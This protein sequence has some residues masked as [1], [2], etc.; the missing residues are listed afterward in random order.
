[1]PLNASDRIARRK[2][3]L[4]SDEINA[5]II[6]RKQQK[7]LLYAVGRNF[8]EAG[9]LDLKRTAFMEALETIGIDG[10]SAEKE[11]KKKITA[12]FSAYI[13]GLSLE[14]AATD[15]RTIVRLIKL[16][17]KKLAEEAAEAA[18]VRVPIAIVFPQAVEGELAIMLGAAGLKRNKIFKRRWEG[19]AELATAQALAAEHGGQIHTEDQPAAPDDLRLAAE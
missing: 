10:K 19:S 14:T 11:E 16:G 8:E 9:L 12:A 3:K 5:A 13:R 4:Q 15:A 2:A 18:K 6:F 17:Q 1:M 7:N